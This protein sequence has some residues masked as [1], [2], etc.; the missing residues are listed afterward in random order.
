MAGQKRRRQCLSGNSRIS[1][2]ECRDRSHRSCCRDQQADR[3]ESHAIL[4]QQH[5]DADERQAEEEGPAWKEAG[6][7]AGECS[8]NG[9]CCPSEWQR[10]TGDH[11]GN[12]GDCWSGGATR[13]GS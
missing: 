12:E 5:Q 11:R 1:K 8:G 6:T 9:P 4:R 13:P 2:S 3:Q 7:K 10:S